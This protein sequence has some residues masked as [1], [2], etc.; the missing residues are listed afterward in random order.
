MCGVHFGR[1]Y[2]VAILAVVMVSLSAPAQAQELFRDDFETGILDPTKWRGLVD[3]RGQVTP[4]RDWPNASCDG[5]PGPG[6]G[7]CNERREAYNPGLEPDVDS[8]AY[9]R[10]L[11]QELNFD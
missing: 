5:L 8:V 7:N 6:G 1:L 2:L 4:Y 11:Q 9:V 10:A 3:A